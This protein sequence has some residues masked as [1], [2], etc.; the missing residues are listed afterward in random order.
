[1]PRGLFDLLVETAKGKASEDLLLRVPKNAVEV[2]ERDL[3]LAGIPK[4]TPE[5]KLDFHALR[6]VFINLVI[7]SG[8]GVKEV[9]DLARHSTPEMT[10][11]VYGRSDVDR[12]AA[13]AEHVGQL[14]FNSDEE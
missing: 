2:F 6:T 8:A 5:G 11:N 4:H 9:Q 10:M 14:V 12:K 7:D 3:A 1:L 13:L